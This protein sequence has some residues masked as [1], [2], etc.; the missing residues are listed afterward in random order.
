MGDLC[1]KRAGKLIGELA[2]G[3]LFLWL[4]VCQIKCEGPLS[5]LHEKPGELPDR[6]SC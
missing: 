1:K 3:Y 6:W 4:V 5:S 2:Y